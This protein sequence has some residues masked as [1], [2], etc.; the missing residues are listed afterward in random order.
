M[1]IYDNE[2]ET[3]ENENWTRI[4]LN[5]NIY[6]CR[7]ENSLSGENQKPWTVTIKWFSSKRKKIIIFSDSYGFALLNSIVSYCWWLTLFSDNVS[8]IKRDI[9]KGPQTIMLP[10]VYVGSAKDLTT[11]AKKWTNIRW[12]C[13]TP[14]RQKP[15]SLHRADELQ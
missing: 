13:E 7:F 11:A 3:K 15:S 1:L 10:T 5:C 9:C 4:K 6:T 12:L 8:S 2:Y 14:S